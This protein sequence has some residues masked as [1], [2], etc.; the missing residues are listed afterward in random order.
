MG[1]GD[2]TIRV[3]ANGIIHSCTLFNGNR[4][5]GLFIRRLIIT[6]KAVLYLLLAGHVTLCSCS[7][8][9]LLPTPSQANHTALLT[10]PFYT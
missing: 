7:F 1:L 5:M 3:N 9:L 6:C 2:K 8:T 10:Y 4:Y